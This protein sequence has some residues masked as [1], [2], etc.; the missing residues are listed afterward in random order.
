M[1]LIGTIYFIGCL[2]V[3]QKAE[4]KMDILRDAHRNSIHGIS[5]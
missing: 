3:P 2:Q 1:E 4:E 5:K